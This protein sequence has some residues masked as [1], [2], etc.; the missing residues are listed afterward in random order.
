VTRCEKKTLGNKVCTTS[1]YWA[2]EPLGANAVKVGLLHFVR[3]IVICSK[4]GI[5]W[6]RGF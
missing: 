6:L 3:A 5:D 2:D 4:V 1:P